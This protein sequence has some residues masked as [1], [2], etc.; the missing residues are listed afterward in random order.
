MEK[1]FWGLREPLTWLH[2][3][4]HGMFFCPSPSAKSWSMNGISAF[5]FMAKVSDPI[6]VTGDYA[7]VL[8][9]YLV[10]QDM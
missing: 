3:I 6:S 7:A 4:Q 1:L 8:I 9:A 2:F 5:Q 10:L